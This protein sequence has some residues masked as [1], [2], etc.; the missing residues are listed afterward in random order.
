LVRVGKANEAGAELETV[1][2]LEPNNA[3]AHNNYG[4]VLLALAR[5]AAA[6]KQFQ[7]AER[8]SPRMPGLAGNLAAARH[9]LHQP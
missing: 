2:R 8:L 1:V 6:L 7:I 4:A 3:D 9:A 5:P